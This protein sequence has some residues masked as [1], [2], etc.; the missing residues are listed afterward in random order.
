M[1]VGGKSGDFGNK[2][3][4]FFC[5]IREGTVGFNRKEPEIGGT[6][7][8]SCEMLVVVVR[9]ILDR[10]IGEATIAILPRNQKLTKDKTKWDS[11]LIFGTTRT[12]QYKKMT[13]G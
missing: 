4:Q 9:F 2:S 12:A 6:S 11:T 7:G 1:N 5:L 3:A 10:I 8:K 13:S